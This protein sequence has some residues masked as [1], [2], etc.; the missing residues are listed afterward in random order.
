[1]NKVNREKQVTEFNQK[2]PSGAKVHLTNDDGEIEET[3]TRSE[4]WL[5]GSG[6]PVVKV[7]GRAG[8]YMLDRIKPI[9]G[10]K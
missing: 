1:M 2:S 5:L 4:A 3:E 8:G 9:E 7:K 10:I 6:V